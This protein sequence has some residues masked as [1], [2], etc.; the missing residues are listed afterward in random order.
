MDTVIHPSIDLEETMH[1]HEVNDMK[2]DPKWNI[3]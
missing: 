3:Q 1:A 2:I